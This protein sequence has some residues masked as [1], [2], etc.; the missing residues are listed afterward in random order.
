MRGL[1]IFYE[2]SKKNWG[3]DIVFNLWFVFKLKNAIKKA[4][5][6][7]SFCRI[8]SLNKCNSPRGSTLIKFSQEMCAIF[9]I[10][11]DSTSAEVLAF[12]NSLPALL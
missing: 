12:G 9:Y 2:L 5:K 4:E 11:L 7:N 10:K 8:S 6:G 1:D 3:P